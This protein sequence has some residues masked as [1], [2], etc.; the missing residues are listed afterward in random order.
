MGNDFGVCGGGCTVV[1]YIKIR[2]WNSKNYLKAEI[3][4]YKCHTTSYTK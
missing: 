3:S 2:W 4:V 1:E